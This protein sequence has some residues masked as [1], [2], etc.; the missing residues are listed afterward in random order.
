MELHMSS[1]ISR[2]TQKFAALTLSLIALGF[3]ASAAHASNPRLQARDVTGEYELQDGSTV[4]I[5]VVGRRVLV[6]SS[7][8]EYWT[9]SNSDLLVSPDGLRKIKLLRDFNGR[10]ERIE[11]ENTSAR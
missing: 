2:S 3:G 7:A 6:V 5:E 11:M 8:P 9:A 1:S 4:R 10:V